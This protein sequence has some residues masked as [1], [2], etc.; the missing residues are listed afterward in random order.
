MQESSSKIQLS[1]TFKTLGQKPV[2]IPTGFQNRKA[3][4]P[5]CRSTGRSTDL[6]YRSTGRSI[7]CPTESWVFTVSRLGRPGG[8]PLF[9]P[10]HVVH[11]GRP[12]FWYCGRSTGPVDRH[13]CF[14]CCYFLRPVPSSVRYR[15]PWWSLDD[16]LTIHVFIL[17]NNRSLQQFSC[18]PKVTIT[19]F[20]VFWW[21]QNICSYLY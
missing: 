13:V 3:A 8:R 19:R 6:F 7:G 15:L 14:Y 2:F 10:V 12:I 18:W 5:A 20:S 4:C 17:D 21:L 16:P 11:I 1:D 9:D